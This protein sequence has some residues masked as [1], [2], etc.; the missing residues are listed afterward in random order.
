M[1][2][3]R[4]HSVDF[5]VF[6]YRFDVD[7]AGSNLSSPHPAACAVLFATHVGAQVVAPPKAQVGDYV[8]IKFQA[9]HPDDP[10]TEAVKR[11][12]GAVGL[13]TYTILK[14][15]HLHWRRTRSVA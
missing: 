15:G 8:K 9:E 13:P 7:D 12:L 3:C 2:S 6:A 1:D 5:E 14:P 4:G 10:T 11:R